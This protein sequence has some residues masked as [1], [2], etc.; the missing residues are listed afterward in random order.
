[1]QKNVGLDIT[2]AVDTAEAAVKNEG[3]MDGKRD[4]KKNIEVL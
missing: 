1:M 2:A 4:N 3:R